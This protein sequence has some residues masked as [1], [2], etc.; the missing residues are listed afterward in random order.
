MMIGNHYTVDL[1]FF[2]VLADYLIMQSW[3]VQRNTPMSNFF[4]ARIYEAVT[5]T[6]EYLSPEVVAIAEQLVKVFIDSFCTATFSETPAKTE[7]FGKNLNTVGEKKKQ[8]Q[9]KKT[10]AGI[11][12]STNCHYAHIW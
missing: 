2:C 8:K 6:S 7:N 10:N 9:K 11:Y 3:I 1:G 4:N 5:K 12:Y